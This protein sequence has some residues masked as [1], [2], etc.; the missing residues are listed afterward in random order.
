MSA[1]SRAEKRMGIS[2]P[3]ELLEEAM[4]LTERKVKTKG[5]PEGYAELLLEDE[6]VDACTRA[7][8]NGRCV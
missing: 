6:I 1:V 8:I 2:A 7:A 3:Q 4:Q 5:L